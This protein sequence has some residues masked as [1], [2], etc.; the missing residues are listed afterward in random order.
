[1]AIAGP[2]PTQARGEVSARVGTSVIQ[3]RSWASCVNRPLY[4]WRPAPSPT[5]LSPTDHACSIARG[6]S[7]SSESTARTGRRILRANSS[8]VRLK[9]SKTI[10]R[11]L[12]RVSLDAAVLISI[13]YLILRGLLR[14]VPS[15]EEGREREVEILVLRHQLKVLSRKAG[16]PNLRRADRVFLSA[17]APRMLP[18]ERRKP[19]PRHSGDAPSL[20]PGTGQTQVDLPKEARRAPADVLAGA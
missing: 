20:A 11:G 4:L 17:A 18:R 6:G 13:F 15:G 7:P 10:V 2:T 19:L 5:D 12:T 8:R 14:F 1:M 9:G 16:R 3:S